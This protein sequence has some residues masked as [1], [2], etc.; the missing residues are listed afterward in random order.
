MRLPHV[1]SALLCTVLLAACGGGSAKAGDTC[2]AEGFLCADQVT[3][4][5]CRLHKWTALPCRGPKGC[6]VKTNL[7]NCDA[8]NNQ[9]GDACSATVEG[10]SIC[11]P[12]GTAVLTC[13]N[14]TFVRT[15]SC[16][17][18]TVAGDEIHC[19]PQ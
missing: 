12:A 5:E 17:S 14:G 9:E 8:A 10:K 18:C 16:S 1:F 13:R 7:V 19:N 11:A 3:A 15:N 4:L 6:Y 2:N